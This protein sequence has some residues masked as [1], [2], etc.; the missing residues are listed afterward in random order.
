VVIV[1]E[2]GREDY[3]SIDATVIEIQL[4]LFDVRT[5]FQTKLDCSIDQILVVKKKNMINKLLSKKKKYKL[6]N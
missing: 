3:G 5:N 6:I 4:K 2:I 1:I